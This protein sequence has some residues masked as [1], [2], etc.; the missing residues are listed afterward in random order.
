MNENT[1]GL[2]RQ[3]FPNRTDLSRWTAAE[4]I[5]AVAATHQLADRERFSAGS[6]P[7]RSP[8]RT[9]TLS[10]TGRCCDHRLSPALADGVAVVDESGDDLVGLLAGPQRH[11]QG[12]EG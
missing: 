5:E 1:N 11:L 6:T 10:S 9:P 12:V 2:L 8:Q 3:Y 7:S 4:D